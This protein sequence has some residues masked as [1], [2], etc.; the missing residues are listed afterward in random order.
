MRPCAAATMAG[1]CVSALLGQVLHR[2]GAGDGAGGFR[3]VPL[4][5]G[6]DTHLLLS[7]TQAVPDTKAHPKQTPPNTPLR[8]V[9]TPC[10]TSHAPPIL[11]KTFTLS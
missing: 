9:N 11:Q 10:T 4:E 1:N 2:S 3:G 8:P 5:A 7:S 6:A